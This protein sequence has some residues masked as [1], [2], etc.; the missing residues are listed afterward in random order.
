M[1]KRA[2]RAIVVFAAFAIA[3]HPASARVTDAQ[4]SAKPAV[5][6]D[7]CPGVITFQ[8]TITTD[9]PGTVEYVFAR[10]DGATDTITKRLVFRRPG[11]QRV[12]TTW[13]LGGMALPY[14]KGWEAIKILAP[15]PATWNQAAFELKCNP[16]LNSALSAHGNTDWH[17]DTANEFLFGKDMGG[18]TT[19]PNY[20]PNTWTKRHMHVGLANTAKFYSDKSKLAAGDDTNATSGIDRAMLFFYAGHGSPKSWSTLGDTGTQSNM[21]MANIAQGGMLRYYWQCSC[22]VFA[23]GPKT[24]PGGGMDYACPQ[25]FAG[26]ADSVN[27]RNVFERWG[28]ALSR[29]LRMA[30]GMSTLAYCHE[31]NVNK[32]WDDYNHGMSVATSFIDGFGDWGVVPICITTGGASIAATPLYDA[33]FKNQPNTSGNSHYHIRFAAGTKTAVK[34]IDIHWIPTELVR[35]KVAAAEIHPRLRGLAPTKPLAL[36][37]FA[38]GSATVRTEPVSGAVYLRAIQPASPT[39]V[40]IEERE[41]SLRAANLLR[42]LGWQD[43]GVGEPVVTNIGTASMPIGGTAAEIKQ[44]QDGALVTYK[45]QIE[46]QGKRIDVLGEGGIMKVHLS[47]NGSIVAATRVWRTLAPMRVPVKIKSFD[48]ARN[49]AAGKLGNADAYQL[50]QWK[51]GYKEAAG[52]VK[53]DELKVV[54]QFAF[55]PKNRDDAMN[56]PPR[57]VEVSAEKN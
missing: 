22:D 1:R 37:G 21:L 15:N 28:P 49:E 57:I 20:A 13:T 44:G 17:I 11:T 18:T 30:C 52:N 26:G 16:A 8:G 54:Y 32:V 34:P 25:N 23:H 19:A 46:V 38:G 43:A 42:E 55:V 41:Y 31:S 4:L 27:S 56:T 36:R 9:R 39:E 35:Y 7:N 14:Y 33:T 6:Q 48:E 24:C 10:S 47:N 2:F 3:G 40:P 45:R 29:D 50:D 53:Q 12:S 51:F 5:F